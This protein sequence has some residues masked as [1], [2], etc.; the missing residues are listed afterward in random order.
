MKSYV[1]YV[2]KKCG[3]E[4][5]DSDEIKKCEASHYGLTLEEMQEWKQLQEYVK[6][7]SSIVSITKNESTERNFDEAIAS[8]LSFEKKHKIIK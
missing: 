7:V 1:A 8:L 2:C 5:R 3:K 4:S 6:S